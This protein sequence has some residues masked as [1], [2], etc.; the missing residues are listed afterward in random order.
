MK[1]V[2]HFTYRMLREKF[3]DIKFEISEKEFDEIHIEVKKGQL[4]NS[5][6]VRNVIHH[7]WKTYQPEVLDKVWFKIVNN[8]MPNEKIVSNMYQ[9]GHH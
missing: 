5:V 1:E 9:K 3:P 2:V 7:Y 4:S 8:T 6:S